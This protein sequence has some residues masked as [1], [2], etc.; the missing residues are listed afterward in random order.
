MGRMSRWGMLLGMIALA[1]LLW[2]GAASAQEPTCRNET[3]EGRAY[4]VCAPSS[5][6]PG[7]PIPVVMVLHG[8]SQNPDDIEAG[9]EMTDYAESRRFVVIYPDQPSSANANR[10]WNWF[11]TAHQSRG[12][13]EPADLV[14]I[15]DQERTTLD[16]ACGETYVAGM[17]AGAAMSVVLGA[18]YPDRFA[19]I[20]VSAGLE[21]QA[22]TDLASGL[23]AMAVGGPDPDAQGVTAYEAMGQNATLVP[24]IVFH[25]TL[26]ATV[27]PENGHQVISQWAQTNDLVLDG[28]D[29]DDIDDQPE[30]VE[31]GQVPGG[32]SYTRSVYHGPEGVLME[33]YIVDGMLHRWSGGSADGSYTDPTG[34]K[35]S[36]IMLDFFFSGPNNCAPTATSLATLGATAP[37]GRALPAAALLVAGTLLGALGWR[38]VGGRA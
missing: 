33:K 4:K 8:C 36:E 27:N 32:R 23:L 34:P 24:T 12:A 5:Y 13:G 35:A 31:S 19:G 17:S 9:T 14:A 37:A 21:Y 11:E 6:Q 20:G 7:T 15:L 25:G 26:D 28:V 30:L 22:G 10:C 16:I 1:W 38:R 18:T 2:P 29:N 3:Y